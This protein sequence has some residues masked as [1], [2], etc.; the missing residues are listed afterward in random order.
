MTIK[1]DSVIEARELASLLYSIKEQGVTVILAED[2]LKTDNIAEL[3]YLVNGCGYTMQG[4]RDS[5]ISYI[6]EIA[7]GG[8]K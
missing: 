6:L 5:A 2:A 8:E 1:I 4:K 3:F 7:P